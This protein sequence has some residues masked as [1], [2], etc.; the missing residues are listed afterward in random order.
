[1]SIMQ[2]HPLDMGFSGAGLSGNSRMLQAPADPTRNLPDAL[3]DDGSQFRIQLPAPLEDPH[4]RACPSTHEQ[5]Q[6]A[7]GNL[8]TNKAVPSSPANIDD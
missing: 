7:I 4:S 6:S 5:E 8:R 2:G 1:M 3:F